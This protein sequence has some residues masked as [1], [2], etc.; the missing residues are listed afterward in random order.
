MP[1]TREA[2]DHARAAKVPI[3]I[4]MNKMDKPGADPDRVKGDL[5]AID[6]IPEDYGGDT[7]IVPVSAKTGQ[8]V[9]DL[10]DMILLT[11]GIVGTKANPEGRRWARLSRRSRIR[12]VAP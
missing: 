7:V 6:L 4:A 8:G 12:S 9:Q 1:Q 2:V 5:A 10:L 11:C 3:I